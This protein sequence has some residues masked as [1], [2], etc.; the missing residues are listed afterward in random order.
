MTRFHL[1]CGLVLIQLAV[2]CWMV[3]SQERTLAEGALFKFKTRPVD[4]V[5][6]FRGRYVQLAFDQEVLSSELDKSFELDQRVYVALGTDDQGFAKVLTVS[7]E[8]P[9]TGS[10]ILART[11]R[12][13]RNR[14]EFPFDRFYMDE[15]KAPKAEAAFLGSGSQ[16]VQA[17]VQVRVR[18]GHAS[19]EDLFLEGLPVKKYLRT[20]EILEREPAPLAE[21]PGIDG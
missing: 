1:F 16:R 3:I 15:F 2:P 19:I 21:P 8:R 14:L 6:F 10:F 12:Y 9:D 17:Y 4:P 18:D 13:E 5:D 20:K 11:S 7:R